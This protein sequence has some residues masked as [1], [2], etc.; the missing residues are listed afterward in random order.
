MQSYGAGGG[1][2]LTTTG[3]GGFYSPQTFEPRYTT[4]G[5]V[6]Q[7]VIGYRMENANTEPRVWNFGSTLSDTWTVNLKPG[8][9]GFSWLAAGA[10]PIM[11]AVGRGTALTMG[12]SSPIV[13]NTAAGNSNNI[14]LGVGS[15]FTFGASNNSR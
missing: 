15:G 8:N 5:S 3:S 13:R 1:P 14:L 4:Y 11:F 7:S 6:I 10:L 12:R 2:I 9:E